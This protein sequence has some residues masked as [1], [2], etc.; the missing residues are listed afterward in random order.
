MSYLR[1]DLLVKLANVT[2][3]LD[4]LQIAIWLQELHHFN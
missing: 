2:I 1:V 3:Y 4:S